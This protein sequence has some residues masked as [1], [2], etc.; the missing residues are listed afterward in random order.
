MAEK[1]REY[2]KTHP[3]INFSLKL[4]IPMPRCGCCWGRRSPRAGNESVLLGFLPPSV[5]GVLVDEHMSLVEKEAA[6][7]VASPGDARPAGRP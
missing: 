3:Y 6:G 1:K 5:D 4:Q 7:V 2:E